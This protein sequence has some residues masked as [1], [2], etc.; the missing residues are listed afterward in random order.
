MRNRVLIEGSGRHLLGSF[1]GCFVFAR[2]L[3]LFCFVEIGANLG[4]IAGI[5]S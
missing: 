2:S 3:L 4:G 5:I 1:L